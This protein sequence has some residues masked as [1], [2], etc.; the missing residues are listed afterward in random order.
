MQYRNYFYNSYKKM[1]GAVLL[2]VILG[3]LSLS[4]GAQETVSAANSSLAAIVLPSN[5]QRVSPENVPAEITR[6]L[7][8]VIAAGGGKLQKGETEVLVWTG[9]NYKKS[10][11]SLTINRLTE[12]L[13]SDGWKYSP[14]TS[15]G[16]LTVF[17]AVK[18]GANRRSLVGFYGATDAAL[19]LAW[20]EVFSDGGSAENSPKADETI[21]KP[22]GKSDGSIVGN[23]DNGRVSTVTRQ[24][25]ITGATTPGSGTRFEYDFAAD[26]RF[27]FTGLMQ[28]TNYS[29]TD[30]LFNEKAG[31]YE[32]N[33]ATLK[34]IPSKN[35]WRKTN[36]CNPNGNSERNYTLTEETYQVSFKT[37]EYGKELICLNDGKS[38]NCYRRKQ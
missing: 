34:L 19:V 38:D 5:T 24:N 14:E 25:T 9:G 23:W 30:T 1:F 16:G 20:M 11:A 13:R 4:A 27:S 21:P 32:L 6:T 22:N 15:E 28:T 3:G 26:G 29:C 12:T 18:E 8:K 31:R 36:S 37:D 35:F 10:N 7:D 2:A 17:T 33:G